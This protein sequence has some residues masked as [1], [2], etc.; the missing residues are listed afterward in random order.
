MFLI[1]DTLEQRQNKI[2][3]FLPGEPVIAILLAAADFEWTVRRAIRRFAHKTGNG[4][5]PKLEKAGGLGT[6]CECWAKVTTPGLDKLDMVVQDWGSLQKSFNLRH[7][8]IHGAQGTTGA[9]FATPRV[10]VFLA[11]S[12][13]VAKYTLEHVGPIYGKKLPPRKKPR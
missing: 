10:E 5:G 2:R 13:S 12:A 8:L 4:P 1:K 11:A 6:Y 7:K 9:S 3:S